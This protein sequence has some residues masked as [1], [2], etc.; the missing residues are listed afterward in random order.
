MLLVG[1]SV[2]LY[3]CVQTQ[4]I[5]KITGP[6]RMFHIFS[7]EYYLIDGWIPS[8]HTHALTIISSTLLL[9]VPINKTVRTPPLS[10]GDR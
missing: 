6:K 9:E 7:I 8:C 10:K 3:T 4:N 2:S 1:Y 5:A